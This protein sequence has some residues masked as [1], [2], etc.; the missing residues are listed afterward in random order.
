VEVARERGR[1]SALELRARWAAHVSE[2][3]QAEPGDAVAH[4]VAAER[5]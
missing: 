4:R 5:G 2:L 3:L 1:H